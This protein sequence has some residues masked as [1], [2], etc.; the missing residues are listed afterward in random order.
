MEKSHMVSF[1]A[2]DTETS[3]FDHH[4]PLQIGAVLFKEGKPAKQYN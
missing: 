1:Y 2:L 3:G 4:E